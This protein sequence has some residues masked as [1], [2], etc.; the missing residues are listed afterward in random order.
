ML[1]YIYVRVGEI[2]FLGKSRIMT[3][4]LVY[5]F[6]M[7]PRFIFSTTDNRVLIAII[8]LLSTDKLIDLKGFKMYLHDMSRLSAC[9][10]RFHQIV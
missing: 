6:L 1:Y 5:M 10:K 7:W 4:I 3:N 8:I 9:T 2:P